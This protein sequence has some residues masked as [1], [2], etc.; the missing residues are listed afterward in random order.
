MKHEDLE[1]QAQRDFKERG[2][3]PVSIQLMDVYNESESFRTI[4]DGLLIN[5]IDDMNA[6]KFLNNVKF[7]LYGS[8]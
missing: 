7:M 5:I 2:K 3:N 8:Y 1:K 4:I 6:E